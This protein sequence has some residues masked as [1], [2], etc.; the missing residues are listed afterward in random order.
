VDLDRKVLVKGE[1][2]DPG[3]PAREWSSFALWH[4]HA[5]LAFVRR[6][7]GRFFLVHPEAGVVVEM[8]RGVIPV[9]WI[10]EG[11]ALLVLRDARRPGPEVTIEVWR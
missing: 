7:K 11:R 4:P 8:E 3:A 6:D 1:P 5:D 10:D 9:A 2:M